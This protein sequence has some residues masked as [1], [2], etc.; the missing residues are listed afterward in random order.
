MTLLVGI[1][2]PRGVLLHGPTGV[3][4]SLLAEAVANKS[5]AQ[6]ISITSQP[7]LLWYD[8]YH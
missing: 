4:K 7:A 6:V 5:G 8:M 2:L 3:G 1:R